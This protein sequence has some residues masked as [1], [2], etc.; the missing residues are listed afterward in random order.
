MNKSHDEAFRKV[1][2]SVLGIPA[3]FGIEEAAE[4]LSYGLKLPEKRKPSLGEEVVYTADS[5]ERMASLK[6]LEKRYNEVQQLFPKEKISSVRDIRRLLDE[7]P[8]SV[9][10]GNKFLNAQEGEESDNYY[11]STHIYRGSYIFDSKFIGFSTDL[12]KCE[13]VYGSH[14]T[15]NSALS[16]RVQDCNFVYNCFEVSWSAKTSNCLF[17]HGVVNQRDSMFC[18]HN[19]SNQYCIANRKYTKEEY[20][21]IRGMV[22][23]EL[24]ENDFSFKFFPRH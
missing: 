21:K 1:F 7:M 24:A 4:K 9:F 5:L 23:K 22:V 8:Y 14:H 13:Y 16:I 17:C 18:F 11:H 19:A 12:T 20:D 2:Q 3:P 10:G 15:N 6:E